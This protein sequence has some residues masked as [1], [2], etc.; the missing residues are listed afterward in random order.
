MSAPAGA[1]GVNLQATAAAALRYARH[2]WPVFPCRPRGKTPCTA[3][4]LKDATTDLGM[5]EGWWMTWP[6][7]N[8]AIRTGR[9]SGLLVLDVDGDD[10]AESLR[11]LEREHG[12]LPA[13]ATVAT[14]R[15]GQHYYFAHPG[16]E[17]RNSASALGAR[18]DVRGDGGYVLAPPSVG[19]NGHSY[20]PDQRAPIADAPGWLRDRLTPP[21]SG[22]GTAAAAPVS[23]WL[24]I[25]RDGLVEGERNQGLTRLVGHLLRRYVDVDLAAELVHLVNRR[26]RPPLD[27]AE[28]DRI[29]ESVCGCEL[30]PRRRRA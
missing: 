22:C 21:K 26:C 10:G 7:A 30:R 23:E 19:A 2:G 15:G 1:G 3:H 17:I 28:V 5:V 25:V 20:Q 29:V 18:L 27:A 8:V 9:S 6:D 4:G 14:P 24:A 16:G 11:T 12:E 13:T